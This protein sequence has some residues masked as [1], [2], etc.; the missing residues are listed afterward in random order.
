MPVTLPISKMSRREKLI[1]METLW[2]D[3]SKDDA[4]IESPAWHGEAL[5]ETERLVKAGKAKFLDLDDA[6]TAL[7]RKIARLS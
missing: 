6:K 5:R 4:D 2:I 3:L 1:A 7:R